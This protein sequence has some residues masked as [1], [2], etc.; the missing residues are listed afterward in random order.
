M[1]A[2][3]FAVLLLCVGCDMAYPEIAVVN[4]TGERILIKDISFNGC[5]WSTVL[6]YDET[7]APQRCLPGK[8]RV[9]FKKLD[10]EAYCREQIE[11]DALDGLCA[12][13]NN[14]VNGND[15]ENETFIEEPNWFNYQTVSIKK[16]GYGDFQ[17]FEITLDAIEQDFA[18]SGPYGH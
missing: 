7:A 13:N 1:S 16:A 4:K 3:I 12:C 8:D 18:A 11:N 5:L 6:A 10:I 2:V 9:H 14:T 17:I 15:I